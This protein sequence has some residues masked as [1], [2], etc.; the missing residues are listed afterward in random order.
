M[1]ELNMWVRD[2]QPSDPYS[3]RIVLSLKASPELT[4]LSGA[5]TSQSRIA[6]LSASHHVSTT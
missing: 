5:L 4:V 3:A 1:I 2:I 6:T